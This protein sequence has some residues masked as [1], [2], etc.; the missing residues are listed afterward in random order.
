MKAREQTPAM[1]EAQERRHVCGYCGFQ[2]DM[3]NVP[4]FCEQCL[5]APYL[6]EEDLYL[7]R[8]LPITAN[9][10]RPPLSDSELAELQPR[11][12]QAQIHGSSERGK[13]RIANKR[14]NIEREYQ[15]S[16]KKAKDKH[17]GLLWLMDRGINTYNV[18]YYDH[19]GKFS[20]LWRKTLSS[21]E[22]SAL[23]AALREF[24]FDHDI[25]TA[26]DAAKDHK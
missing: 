12:L 10:T 4:T 16:I 7:L 25:I 15:E 21:L 23:L 14:A 26:Q 17:D 8:M 13:A 11:Y 5:D 9:R 20:F 1:R 24:P 6:K 3:P 22:K 2:A 19:T 18:I